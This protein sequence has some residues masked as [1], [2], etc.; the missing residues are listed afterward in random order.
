MKDSVLERLIDGGK[1]EYSYPQLSEES[2]ISEEFLV[3]I[4]KQFSELGLF[5][6]TPFT[7]GN[8]LVVVRA[9]AHDM[10]RRGGFTAREKYFKDS[11]EKLEREV[12]QLQT[13]FPDRAERFA[14]ILSGISAVIALFR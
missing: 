2:S 14:N 13:D 8:F 5:K 1:C 12:K 10:A 4:I 7:G 9:E 3:I 11:V 6:I